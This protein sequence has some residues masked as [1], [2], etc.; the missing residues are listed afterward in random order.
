LRRV[1]FSISCVFLPIGWLDQEKIMK[2]FILGFMMCF[3]FV[4]S[5]HA[6]EV[7]IVP[8]SEPEEDSSQPWVISFDGKT[9][10]NAA[11]VGKLIACHDS[12]KAPQKEIFNEMLQH[13]GGVSELKERHKSMKRTPASTQ[14]IAISSREH[15]QTFVETV[16]KDCLSK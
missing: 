13:S 9:E 7:D 15:S 1:N 16:L 10:V 12:F 5:V 2:K 11:F 4:A 3:S 14:Q 6:V 8:A